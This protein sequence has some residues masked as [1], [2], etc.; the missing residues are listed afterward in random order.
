MRALAVHLVHEAL[1]INIRRI[2]LV[3]RLPVRA[4]LELMHYGVAVLVT[5]DS[6]GLE[7]LVRVKGRNR[8]EIVFERLSGAI[9]IKEKGPEPFGAADGP[10]IPSR[11]TL[12]AARG[13][14]PERGA[15]ELTL[16]IVADPMVGSDD[17]TQSGPRAAQRL[18]TV[19]WNDIV[20]RAH[21]AIAAAD[22]QQRLAENRE[23][24]GIPDIRNAIAEGNGQ[25]RSREPV[26][27]LEFIERRIEECATRQCA[28]ALDGLLD[29]S[30]L[31]A[32]QQTISDSFVWHLTPIIRLLCSNINLWPTLQ[33][34]HRSL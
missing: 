23:R 22:E 31:R 2:V 19:V 15:K 24:S 26:A 5:A 14:V 20:E 1:V 3:H 6:K 27:Y 12:A 30:D 34:G 7:L 18:A 9:E 8:L 25:P 11:N 33:A 28:G 29:R 16:K 13:A 17:L 10:Q 21:P 32:R 4:A